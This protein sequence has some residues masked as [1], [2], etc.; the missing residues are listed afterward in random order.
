MSDP[1]VTMGP[2]VR[3]VAAERVVAALDAVR[4][5]MYLHGCPDGG[6]AT[7]AAASLGMLGRLFPHG[8][9]LRNVSPDAK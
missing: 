1:R 5:I 7:A 3:G 8:P 6:A 9:V 2:G 4:P